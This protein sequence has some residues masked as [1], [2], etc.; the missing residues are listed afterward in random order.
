MLDEPY[1]I[2][3]RQ[4]IGVMDARARELMEMVQ[5]ELVRAGRDGKLPAGIIVSGGGAKLAGFLSLVKETL[6]LP[7]RAAKVHGVEAFEAAMDPAF[8]VPVGVV[9]WGFSREAGQGTR[10]EGPSPLT[11]ILGTVKSWLK[12]FVP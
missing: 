7:V 3:R 5:A 10:P 9:A 2:E 12:A 8:S 6:G 4:L 11:G 1:I